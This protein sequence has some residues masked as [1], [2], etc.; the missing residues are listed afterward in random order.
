ME[1]LQGLAAEEGPQLGLP[2]SRLLEAAEEELGGREEPLQRRLVA[3]AVLGAGQLG[4]ALG[5]RHLLGPPAEDAGQ[6]GDHLLLAEEG[7]VKGVGG[8]LSTAFR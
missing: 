8:Q 4:Q 2:L 1:S 5:A 6:L 3:G 7:L